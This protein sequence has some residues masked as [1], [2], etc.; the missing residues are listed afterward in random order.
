MNESGN[1]TLFHLPSACPSVVLSTCPNFEASTSVILEP[2]IDEHEEPELDTKPISTPKRKVKAKGK[3]PLS[4]ADVRRS[5]RLKLVH[6]GFKTSACKDRNCLGC[7]STPPTISSKVIRNLGASFCGRNPEDL[8]PSK[9][10]AKPAKKKPVGKTKA[11]PTSKDKAAN[12]EA[13]PKTTATNDV[14]PKTIKKK[15]VGKKNAKPTPDDK[16]AEDGAPST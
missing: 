11:K 10:N 14:Q 13:Q 7:S 15:V 2:I 1:V 16:P 9:L 12:D 3:A 4:E 6:K 5:N 8:S